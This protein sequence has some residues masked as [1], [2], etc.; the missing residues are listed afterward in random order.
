MLLGWNKGKPEDVLVKSSY[1]N[2]FKS[3]TFGRAHLF[4]QTRVGNIMERDM[5]IE[6]VKSLI[7]SAKNSSNSNDALRFSQAA[8]NCADAKRVLLEIKRTSGK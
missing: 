2:L 4:K 5:G 3:C 8:C 7:E 1:P 6:A